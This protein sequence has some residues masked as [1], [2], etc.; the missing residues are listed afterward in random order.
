M[1]FPKSYTL[2]IT[3]LAFSLIYQNRWPSMNGAHCGCTRTQPDADITSHRQEESG[4][5]AFM[6]KVHL[7][8]STPPPPPT[9]TPLFSPYFFFCYFYS[10]LEWSD[11]DNP[12]SLIVSNHVFK[13]FPLFLLQY[14][15]TRTIYETG[16]LF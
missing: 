5:S 2:S 16:Q 8:L 1:G 10:P 14:N 9:P 4:R 12:V 13:S 11:C 6:S 3:S 15:Y 7:Q